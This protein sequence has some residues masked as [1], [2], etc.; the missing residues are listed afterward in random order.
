MKTFDGGILMSCFE[1]AQSSGIQAGNTQLHDLNPPLSHY[2]IASNGFN[3][4][5]W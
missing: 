2:V 5:I 1:M 3:V 4:M